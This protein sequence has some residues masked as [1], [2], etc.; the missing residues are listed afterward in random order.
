MPLSPALTSWLLV[1]RCDATAV[2]TIRRSP[3][4]RDE[5]ERMLPELKAAALAPA[6]PDQIRAIVGQRFALF[7]QPKRDDGEWAAWWA[8][9]YDALEGLT[10]SA[11]EAGMAAWVRSPDA[12]FLCKPGKLADLARSTHV[13]SK[14]SRA[15]HRAMKATERDPEKVAAPQGEKLPPK[16]VV[17]MLAETLEQLQRCGERFAP[18]PKHEPRPRYTPPV[19][20]YGITPEMRALRERQELDY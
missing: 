17:D 20:D 2:E 9:Y 6:T 11:I 7:P 4:L 5:A 8:D 3:I 19:D 18:K 14:W 13:P 10:P 1:E 15:A 16:V 12:E